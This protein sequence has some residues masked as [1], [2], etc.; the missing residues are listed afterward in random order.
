M[1][2]WRTVGGRRIFIKDGQDLETAMTESGKFDSIIN[3]NKKRKSPYKTI[4]ISSQEY[5]VFQKEVNT[6][7][8]KNE[9]R[10]ILAKAIGNYYYVFENYG[11]NEYNIFLKIKIK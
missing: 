4:K 6:Y 3:K 2:I 9:N 11:F 1:G 7:Y 10:K 8:G 5:A